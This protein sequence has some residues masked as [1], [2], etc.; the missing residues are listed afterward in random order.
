MLKSSNTNLELAI[1]QNFTLII[2]D[3]QIYEWF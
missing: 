1:S 3:F 2:K